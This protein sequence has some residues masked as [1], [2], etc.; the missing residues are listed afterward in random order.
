M[1]KVTLINKMEDYIGICVDG[2][3]KFLLFDCT[4]V[5]SVMC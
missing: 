1:F 4:V 2:N 5:R 3:G